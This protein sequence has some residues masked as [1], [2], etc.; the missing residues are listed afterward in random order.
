[1]TEQNAVAEPDVIEGIGSPDDESLG[2]YPPRHH[3]DS[4]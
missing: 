1:M 2:E 3:D 4:Q